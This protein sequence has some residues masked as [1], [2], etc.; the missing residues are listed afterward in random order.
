[1]LKTI[2]YFSLECAPMVL[3]YLVSFHYNFRTSTALY[4]VATT[5]V[6]VLMLHLQQRLPYLS[7]IF[8]FFVVV[9]GIA[10]VFID[11]PD[12]IILSDSIYFLLGAAY[13]GYSLTH[14]RTL[15]QVLFEPAFAISAKG[16][17]TLTW[18]W[19]TVFIVAGVSNEIVRVLMTP[20]WWIGF[21]FWRGC[22]ITL[23]SLGFFY[24][25]RHH[26]L[27]EATAWGIR[28]TKD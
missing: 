10:T 18:C 14:K 24:I 26:R 4:V 5:I 15:L 23:I 1:M 6:V 16:W 25:T 28:V 7:L 13:L 21:Q 11:N 20:E 27:P 22:A 12:I 19:I 9:S 17:R 8:G 2:A 3:Y